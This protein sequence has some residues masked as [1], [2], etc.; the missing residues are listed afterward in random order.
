MTTRF[1]RSCVLATAIISP[2]L[3]S[4]PAAANSSTSLVDQQAVSL[5]TNSVKDTLSAYDSLGLG[6]AVSAKR[7]L[8]KALRDMQQAVAKDP[9]LALSEKRASSLHQE[10]KQLN[11]KMSSMDSFSA[12]A[13]LET[14]LSSAG[15]FPAS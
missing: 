7:Q 11:T 13:E 3:M 10:L 5:L 6:D 4:V 9:S 14:V 1:T 8:D 15:I 2:L 12:K